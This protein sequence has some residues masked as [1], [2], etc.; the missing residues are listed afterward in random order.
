MLSRLLLLLA[1]S[2]TLVSATACT[3]LTRPD[4][5]LITAE[6][7]AP[8]PAPAPAPAPQPAGQ[9]GAPPPHATGG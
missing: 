4:E 3:S 9:P 8:P 6:R 5:I 2:A 7:A 1:A